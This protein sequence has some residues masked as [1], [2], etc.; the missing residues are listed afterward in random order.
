MAKASRIVVDALRDLFSKSNRVFSS[1]KGT[2]FFQAAPAKN[3]PPEQQDPP[4][5]I[6]G[7]RRKRTNAI[8]GNKA[9]KNRIGGGFEAGGKSATA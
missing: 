3:T 5:Q 4:P 1:N 9:G 2:G 6:V 8:P 7:V